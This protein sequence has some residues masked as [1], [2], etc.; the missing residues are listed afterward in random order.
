MCKELEAFRQL[1]IEKQYKLRLIVK[2][3]DELIEI[4]KEIARLLREVNAA[5]AADAA[6]TK[7]SGATESTSNES[8][9]QD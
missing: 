6:V 1:Q 4:S 3:E 8:S 2:L 7:A 9:N 5:D